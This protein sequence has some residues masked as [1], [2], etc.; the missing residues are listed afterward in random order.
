MSEW[1]MLKA[2]LVYFKTNIG[3]TTKK[4][5]QYVSKSA[6]AY[7]KILNCAFFDLRETTKN[8]SQ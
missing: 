7:F 2:F 6:V 4:K 8:F 5:N 1:K 3:L